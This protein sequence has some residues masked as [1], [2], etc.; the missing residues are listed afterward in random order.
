MTITTASLS[1]RHHEGIRFLLRVG[2]GHHCDLP[3]PRRPI[4]QPYTIPVSSGPEGLC[5]DAVLPAG[6]E[7]LVVVF[8]RMCSLLWFLLNPL[9]CSERYDAYGVLCV[10]C[11]CDGAVRIPSGT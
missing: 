3:L 10:G 6:A 4:A 9:T 11:S 1:L 8:A 5:V 2:L 7:D